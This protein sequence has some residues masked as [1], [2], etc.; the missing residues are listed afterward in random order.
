MD[1]VFNFE[2]AI[3]CSGSPHNVVVVA[4]FMSRALLRTVAYCESSDVACE[5]PRLVGMSKQ[6]VW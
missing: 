2:P 1:P 4:C 6:A 3:N 5:Y